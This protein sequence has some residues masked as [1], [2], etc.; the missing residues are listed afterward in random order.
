MSE[1]RACAAIAVDRSTVRSRRRRPDDGALRRRMREM[2]RELTAL[3]GR[4]GQPA[5]IVS[6]NVLPN[7][8]S[9]EPHW[10][11]WGLFLLRFSGWRWM[12]TV[13]CSAT[14]D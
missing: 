7:L 8:N 2:A 12:P 1:R 10:F 13:K 4:R 9:R 11:G 14:S 6:D 5:F 3:I